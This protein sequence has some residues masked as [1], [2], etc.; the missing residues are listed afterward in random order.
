M[1]ERENFTTHV[2]KFCNLMDELAIASISIN[3]T[4]VVAN[5]L[6]SIPEFYAS[7]IMVQ[8]RN[9]GTLTNTIKL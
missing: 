8:T 7:I 4:N 5:L 3:D 1:F 6:G 2:N 9:I